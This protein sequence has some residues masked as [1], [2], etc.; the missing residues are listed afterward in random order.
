MG[1][2]LV[3]AAQPKI[4]KAYDFLNDELKGIHT[5]RATP[6]LVEEID[7]EVYGGQTMS[8]KQLASISVPDAKSITITPWDQATLEPIEKAIRNMQSLGFNPLNDGQALHINVPPLTA[9]RREQLVKQVNEKV[10][11]CYI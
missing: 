4:A 3:E 5:G 8:I 1:R 2:D 9:E 10:E 6:G 7:A 11:N